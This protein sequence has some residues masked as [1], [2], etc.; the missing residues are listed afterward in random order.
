VADRI[1]ETFK[2]GGDVLDLG[3]GSGAMSLRLLDLGFRVTAADIVGEKFGLHDRVTL[4]LVDL[5]LSFSNEFN[6]VF[7]GIVAIEVLEHLENPR[8]FLKECLKVLKPEGRL[9]ITTPNVDNPVSKALFL[10]ESSFMWFNDL[11][12]ETE[13]HITPI[14]QWQLNKLIHE[15]RLDIVSL[16]SFGD[17]Y[18]HLRKSWKKM[19]ILAK[20]IEMI[21]NKR[22][23][24]MGEIL[25]AVLRLSDLL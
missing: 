13:G 23:V 18:K 5:N 17:P 8:K 15:C 21:R 19:Y 24:L 6:T 11:D 10:R 25:V 9:L 4:K 12:Y 1:V 2:P 14:T 20:L 16:T 22:N 3:A 7:D